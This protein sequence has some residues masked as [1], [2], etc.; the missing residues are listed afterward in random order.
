MED[1]IKYLN[2]F[3]GAI[4][5]VSKLE[6]VSISEITAQIA[7]IESEGLEGAY[8]EGFVDALKALQAIAQKLSQ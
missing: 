1:K 8:D 4:K 6:S 2:G 5:L 3:A 7:D